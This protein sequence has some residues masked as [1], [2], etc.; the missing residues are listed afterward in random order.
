[1]LSSPSFY[2]FI[3]YRH[4]Q[5]SCHLQNSSDDYALVGILNLGIDLAYK[6]D[7]ESFVSICYIF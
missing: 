7:I 6:R 3:H 4:S 5:L 1:M 2:L